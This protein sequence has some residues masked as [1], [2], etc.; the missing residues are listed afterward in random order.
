MIVKLTTA[1]LEHCKEIL[2]KSTGNRSSKAAG[3]PLAGR[4]TVDVALASGVACAAFQKMLREQYKI[5][6]APIQN[7]DF[8][9]CGDASV[10]TV[11]DWRISVV[12][13]LWNSEW[14]LVP[15]DELAAQYEGDRLSHMWVMAIPGWMVDAGHPGECRLTGTVE[16]P[17]FACLHRLMPDLVNTKVM[18]QGHALSDT[19]QQCVPKDCFAIHRSRLYEDWVGFGGRLAALPYARRELYGD[20]YR[21]IKE[22]IQF[23][24]VCETFEHVLRT[25]ELKEAEIHEA[26]RQCRASSLHCS[27]I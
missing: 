1:E 10:V 21:E 15:W 18:Y 3:L 20:T 7:A 25:P 9:A 17:G 16:F 23:N 19:E 2:Q 22:R 4:G 24:R 14:L 12:P 13:A 5:E 27:M 8:W 6:T 11:H 26:K